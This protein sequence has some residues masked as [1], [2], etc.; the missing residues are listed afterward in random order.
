MGLRRKNSSNNKKNSVAW[1]LTPGL[2]SVQLLRWVRLFATPWTA[3]R[4]ASLSITNS[5]SLLKLKLLE[6]AQAQIQAH[7]VGDVIQPSRPLC[8][9]LLL[10]SVFRTGAG[11][12]HAIT[13]SVN[14]H[15]SCF[16][17]LCYFYS[18]AE[19]VSH[20]YASSPSL[21]DF[22]P[23]QVTTE[24]SVEPPLLYRRFS[25]VAYFMLGFPGCSESKKSACNAGD[26]G[27]ISGLGRSLGEGNGNRLHYSCLRNPI[28]RE[29]WPAT[30]HGLIKSRTGLLILY[31]VSMLILI[32]W[33]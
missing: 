28:D 19:Q 25:L 22:L 9:L 29:D 8:P 7:R 24:H 12:G 18:A 27:S 20:T 14:F 13:L 1:R 5:Q 6:P 17:V 33:D 4:Q 32:S 30:V 31:V 3:A 26:P 2:V 23:I 21:S 11:L 16:T 15:Y 10:P